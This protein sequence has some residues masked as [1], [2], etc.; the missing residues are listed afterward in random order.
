[1]KNKITILIL[2][3]AI[4]FH[5]FPGVEDIKSDYERT[6]RINDI[7]EVENGE[8]THQVN[9]L[10]EFNNLIWSPDI[11]LSNADISETS[12][13]NDD[14]KIYIEDNDI[15]FNTTITAYSAT[16]YNRK[17]A[18]SGSYSLLSTDISVDDSAF[19]ASLVLD[20]S[21]LVIMGDSGDDNYSTTGNLAV[22]LDG[23]LEWESSSFTWKTKRTDS[24]TV[25]DLPS[26]SNKMLIGSGTT[27]VAVSLEITDGNSGMFQTLDSSSATTYISTEI[28]TLSE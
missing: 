2:S 20:F 14:T 10:S 6:P 17:K 1:M 13:V 24:S 23:D 4:P 25:A 27:T 3:F 16:E 9:D 15:D 8:P 12:G 18:T 11:D 7:Y 26:E 19:M 28:T 21:D 5:V 22:Y